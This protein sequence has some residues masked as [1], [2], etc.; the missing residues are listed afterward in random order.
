MVVSR[1]AIFNIRPVLEE[2]KILRYMVIIPNGT[3]V[4]SSP[5][6]IHNYFQLFILNNLKFFSVRCSATKPTFNAVAKNW[7]NFVEQ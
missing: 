1:S 5:M 6:A 7:A 4:S 2:S 3:P